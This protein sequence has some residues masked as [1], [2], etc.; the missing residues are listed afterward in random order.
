MNR[1]GNSRLLAETIRLLT[2]ALD[3]LRRGVDPQL[4]LVDA[5][6]PLQLHLQ[7]E[8]LLR[9]QVERSNEASRFS[10]EE[11]DRAIE[12]IDDWLARLN[13]RDI[14]VAYEAAE[15]LRTHYS[16]LNLLVKLQALES[17]RKLI[18]D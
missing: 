2:D 4:L 15:A 18:G 9:A 1:I 17:K 11:I 6:G 13:G 10:A 5:L 12:L 16:P 3:A 8:T 14:V 7:R